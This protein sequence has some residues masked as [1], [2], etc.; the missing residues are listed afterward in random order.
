VNEKCGRQP[1]GYWK[2]QHRIGAEMLRDSKC[3]A[4]V[5]AECSE[6]QK[7]QHKY[8]SRGAGES[9]GMNDGESIL[10]DHD[11]QSA[12]EARGGEDW[13]QSGG[14][15]KH[16]LQTIDKIAKSSNTMGQPVWTTSSQ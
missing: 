12:I 5:S 3:L 2:Q 16:T 6:R 4:G 9:S 13:E 7:L 10:R 14:E 8:S 1:E 15:Q 11:L